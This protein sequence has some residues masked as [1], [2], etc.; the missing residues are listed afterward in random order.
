L[1]LINESLR[2][3]GSKPQYWQPAD[4]IGEPYRRHLV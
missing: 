4:K 1:A 3:R 2:T